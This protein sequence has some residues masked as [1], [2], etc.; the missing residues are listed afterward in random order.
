M[1]FVIACLRRSQN[2]KLGIF[3]G[4]ACLHGGG[5][6]QV[7][8]VTCLGGVKK[9]PSFTCNLTTPPSRCALSQDY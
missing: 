5:G 6:P 3:I 4:R 1:N 2:V 7:R 8:E 9:Y